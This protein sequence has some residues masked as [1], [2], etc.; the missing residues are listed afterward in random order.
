MMSS[1]FGMAGEFQVAAVVHKA[2]CHLDVI[3]P[4]ARCGPAG[5]RREL[6]LGGT[7]ARPRP[8]TASPSTSGSHASGAAVLRRPRVLMM[9]PRGLRGLGQTGRMD[10]PGQRLAV[11]GVLCRFERTVLRGLWES[12]YVF[13]RGL[14]GWSASACASFAGQFGGGQHHCGECAIRG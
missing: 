9:Q 1:T 7:R 12:M 4:R 14:C 11:L 13:L 8:D 10:Q 6:L 3:G 2:H 5:V